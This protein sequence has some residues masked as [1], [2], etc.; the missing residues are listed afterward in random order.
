[1]RSEAD[2]ADCACVGGEVAVTGLP[3]VVCVRMCVCVCV[4]VR[5]CVFV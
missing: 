1:M 2:A 4:C 5:V 3:A